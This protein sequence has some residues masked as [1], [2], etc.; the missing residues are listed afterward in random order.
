LTGLKKRF[1]ATGV[2]PIFIHT[3]SFFLIYVTSCHT[4][5][6]CS[7][8]LVSIDIPYN[9]DQSAQARQGVLADTALGAFTGDVIWHDDNPDQ[10]ETLPDNA[11]HRDVELM[12]IDADKKGKSVRGS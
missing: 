6:S 11:L 10:I 2:P 8:E 9:G 12:I 4:Q 7:P 5:G 1:D 3:V